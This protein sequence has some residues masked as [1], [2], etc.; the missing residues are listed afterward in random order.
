MQLNRCCYTSFQLNFGFIFRDT[1]QNAIRRVVFVVFTVVVVVVL[2][3]LT[4]AADSCLSR[5][6]TTA[7]EWI[8]QD[9]GAVRLVKLTG[10]NQ[11]LSITLCHNCGVGSCLGFFLSASQ[12]T[13]CSS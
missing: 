2:K 13:I 6:G 10:N 8:A 11:C 9:S 7:V 1:T 5:S 4:Q 3:E 12:T